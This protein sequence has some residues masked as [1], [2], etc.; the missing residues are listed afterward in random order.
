MSQAL[1]VAG[2]VF[3]LAFAVFHLLFWK[4]FRW[5]EELS[6]LGAINRGVMQV[7]NI[8]LIYV[9]LFLAWLALFH[10]P[11]MLGTDLG[12]A[13]LGSVSLFWVL[14]AVVDLIFFQRRHWVAWLLFVLFICGALIHGIP[15]FL[16]HAPSPA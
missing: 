12:R 5:K 3:H 9:F 1:L 14:R 6:R 15:L 13:L 16:P 11:A 2:A 8:C 10:R 4:L 7:L